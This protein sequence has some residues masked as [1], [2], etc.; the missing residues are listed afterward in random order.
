MTRPKRI[1][2]GLYVGAMLFGA[3]LL[4]TLFLRYRVYYVVPPRLLHIVL[5]NLLNFVFVAVVVYLLLPDLP[6]KNDGSG[7]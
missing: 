7:K 1:L 5:G 6:G 3:D 2:L 4:V